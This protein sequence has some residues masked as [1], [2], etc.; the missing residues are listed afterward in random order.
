MN[1]TINRESEKRARLV[2]CE[3]CAAN[4]T[5]EMIAL[6]ARIAELQYYQKRF[7]DEARDLKKELRERY[8]LEVF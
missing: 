2:Q 7:T 6:N 1:T 5:E 8:S 4:V 3:T